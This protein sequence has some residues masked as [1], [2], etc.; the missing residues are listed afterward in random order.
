MHH[1]WTKNGGKDLSRGIAEMAKIQESLLHLTSHLNFISIFKN[2]NGVNNIDFLKKKK[3][4]SINY[5]ILYIS[6]NTN[7]K[8]QR[9]PFSQSQ[10]GK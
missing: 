1:A 9:V 4:F 7:L 10:F 3:H 8:D 5:Q 2:L 6:I